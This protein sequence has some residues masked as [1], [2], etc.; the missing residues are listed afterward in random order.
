MLSPKMF[1]V[2]LGKCRSQRKDEKCFNKLLNLLLIQI[3]LTRLIVL[4]SVYSPNSSRIKQSAGHSLIETLRSVAVLLAAIS[5]RE[6]LFKGISPKFPT[7]SLRLKVFQWKGVRV[8]FSLSVPVVSEPPQRPRSKT[9]FVLQ[10]SQCKQFAPNLISL[11][12]L[13]S[14][15]SSIDFGALKKVLLKSFS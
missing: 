2:K 8:Q 3:W 1:E 10:S 9:K 11:T 5:L 6:H 13:T 7:I 4:L 14:G 12:K 15:G